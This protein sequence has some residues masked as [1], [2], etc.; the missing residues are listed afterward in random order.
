MDLVTFTLIQ[1][2]VI[3]TFTHSIFKKISFVALSFGRNKDKKEEAQPEKELASFPILTKDEIQIL[4]LTLKEASF[5]GEH[6]E[7]V[8][9]L[10]LKLQDMYTKS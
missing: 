9:A 3:S 8:Y 7:R 2:Q 1:L 4:L 10:V 5:K 6:I